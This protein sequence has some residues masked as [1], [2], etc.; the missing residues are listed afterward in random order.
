MLKSSHLRSCLM[1]LEK[2]RLVKIIILSICLQVNF[3]YFIRR[4]I[5]MQENYLLYCHFLKLIFISNENYKKI[6]KQYH[7]CRENNR[8]PCWAHFAKKHTGRGLLL[9]V[10]RQ[11]HVVPLEAYPLL[12]CEIHLDTSGP[13]SVEVRRIAGRCNPR[14]AIHLLPTSML[15]WI[16]ELMDR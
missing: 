1:Y 12:P 9:V 6:Y 2:L 4:N 16:K 14:K 7:V 10:A 13:E 5:C 11:L 15:H 8:E 3:H